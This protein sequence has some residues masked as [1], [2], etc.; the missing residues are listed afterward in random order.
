MTVPPDFVPRP[1]DVVCLWERHAGLPAARWWSIEWI[2]DQAGID[3]WPE[4]RLYGVS[5]ITH[6]PFDDDHVEV[7]REGAPLTNRGVCPL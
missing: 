4:V 5:H 1:G 7:W 3:G 2:G 6:I